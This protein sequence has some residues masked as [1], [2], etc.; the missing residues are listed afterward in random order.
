MKRDAK[1]GKRSLE[2]TDSTTPKRKKKDA[3]IIHRYPMHCD[4][5][6]DVEDRK[7]M[8]EHKKAIASELLKTKPRDSIL[9]PLMK[10]TFGGRRMLVLTDD[11]SVGEILEEYPAL[12][13]PVIVRI[14]IVRINTSLRVHD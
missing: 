12:N 13:R 3:D 6:D 5:N 7:T 2:Y 1:K 11:V 14:K 10:S 4:S 9:L 8:K